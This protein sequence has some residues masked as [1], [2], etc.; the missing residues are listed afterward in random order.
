MAW[1]Y[2]FR[3]P[4]HNFVNEVE[5]PG[6]IGSDRRLSHHAQMAQAFAPP[7]PAQRPSLLPVQPFDPFVIHLPAFPAD[8]LV[9]Q[10]AAPAPPFLS[11]GAQPLAQLAVAIL[12]WRMPETASRNLDQ[13]AGTTLRQTVRGDDRSHQLSLHRGP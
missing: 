4:I 13:P 9:E 8:D 6:L 2:P 1:P 11:Q 10:R 3:Y 12:A 7:P 5:R